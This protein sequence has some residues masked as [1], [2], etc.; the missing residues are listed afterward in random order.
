M[1][2][3]NERTS[4]ETLS[5]GTVLGSYEILSLLGAGGMGEVYRARDTRLGREVAIKVLPAERLKDE[6]RRR[7]FVHEARTLSSLSHPNIVTIHAIESAGEIDFM[8]MELVRGT[9]LDALVP[10]HGLPLRD[11]LRLAVPIADA[12]AAAHAHGIIHRDLKP[13]N[14]VVRDDGTVKVL[15]FGLAKLMETDEAPPLETA[16]D[17]RDGG[18]TAAGRVAGTAGYMAPEQA[19]G[20]RVDARSDVFSF[21]AL[22]Y[23]MATGRRAFGG[24]TTA[25]VLAA[26]VSAQ[27]PP[28]TEIVRGLP[29][30]LER[31]ILRC[32]RKEPERRYQGMLDV[33]NELQDIREEREP[34][35]KNRLEQE[36]R[37][38]ASVVDERSRQADSPVRWAS[39]GTASIAV[40]AVA[41]IV[42]AFSPLG[43][44]PPSGRDGRQVRFIVPVP[45]ETTIDSVPS[46][47]YPAVSPLGDQIAFVALSPD[48]R[49]MLWL[50]QLDRDTPRPLEG[51]DGAAFPFWSPD[52]RFIAFAA[53]GKLKKVSAAGG[54][55]QTLCDV[56]RAPGAVHPEWSAGGAWSSRGTIL[57]GT[58]GGLYAVAATGGKPTRVTSLASDRGETSHRF[59]HFLPDGRRF[60]YLVLS[61]MPEYQGIFASSLDAAAPKRLV[62]ATSN[63]VYVEPGLLLYVRDADLVA[64]ALDPSRLEPSGEPTTIAGGVVRAPTVRYAPFSASPDVLVYRSGGI[65]LMRLAWVDRAGRVLGHVHGPARYPG[66][67][68]LSPDGTRLA[69]GVLDVQAGSSD[70]WAIDLARGVPERLTFHP[71]WE[72]MPVWAPGGQRLLFA[73]NRDGPWDIY[74]RELD[75]APQTEMVPDRPILRSLTNTYPQDW[76][77]D[78]AWLAYTHSDP[79]RLTR[80]DIWL[81][82]AVGDRDPLPLLR[83]EFNEREAQFS[84]DGRWIAYTSDET[85]KT[86]VFVRSMTGS[87]SRLKISV[88]GGGEPR[89]RAD[90]EELFYVGPARQMMVVD[91]GSA[92]SLLPGTPRLL[93]DTPVGQTLHWDYVV[94]RDGQ[95]FIIKQPVGEG[96]S[97]M[98]VVLNWRAALGR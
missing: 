66:S 53:G 84:P 29:H 90:G 74:E 55:P 86:D 22:L 67:P 73:S 92:E 40:A 41:L 61:R 47:P 96:S 4:I 85:G 21:G 63:A 16:T 62:N 51:T 42:I 5:S 12:L 7:R 44:P 33:R 60:I 19:V 59:P 77:P 71:S 83:T 91:I 2:Q 97:P 30:E 64:H 36:D 27:P 26:V 81:L 10:G 57:F 24:D 87:G 88:D 89:W 46:E 50:R 28:P 18:L 82:A 45:H 75:G 37:P 58:T 80:E 52:G 69:I 38:D 98:T 56:P 23:E 34:G 25:E 54:P 9:S 3:R 1:T 95:R 79:T 14:I 72:L 39:A 68:A 94:T 13:A 6:H 11:L 70:I 48:G 31:V 32:L 15:D 93:F 76:S 78:G 43:R 17:L 8:V 65:T 20:G 49:G 35:R